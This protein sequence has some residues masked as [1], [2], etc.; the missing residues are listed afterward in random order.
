MPKLDDLSHD[1]KRALSSFNEDT[2]PSNGVDD[3]LKYALYDCER[4]VRDS[5][6]QHENMT[7]K[8]DELKCAILDLTE[9]IGFHKLR[10]DLIALTDAVREL[11]DQQP[12]A[13][14][15]EGLTAAIKQL[16]DQLG[17]PA[18]D[19]VAAPELAPVTIRRPMQGVKLA[20]RRGKRG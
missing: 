18:G 2:T 6:D 1:H 8:M 9:E 15:F 11:A 10:T 20:T 4:A 5:R 3:Q 13:D 17:D 19:P 14:H 16:T 12:T 7:A